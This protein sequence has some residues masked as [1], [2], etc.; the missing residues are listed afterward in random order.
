MNNRTPPRNS[1]FDTGSHLK[2]RAGP[3]VLTHRREML[4]QLLGVT[5]VATKHVTIWSRDID[6]GLFEYPGFIEVLK[7]L[8][9]AGRHVRVRILLAHMP[10]PREEQHPLLL[11]A[12]LFPG[13]FDV[14][15]IENPTMDAAELIVTDESAVLY[16]IHADRWDGMS[17]IHDPNVARFYQTQFNSSWHQAV[18]VTPLLSVSG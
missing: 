4:N 14:R 8:V 10:A 17:D 7:R 13:T 18:P 3:V 1:F 5:R 15:T 6:S 2:F 11:L 9:L 12:E 16:R